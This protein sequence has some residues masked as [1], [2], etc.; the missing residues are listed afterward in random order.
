MTRHHHEFLPRAHSEKFGEMDE[1]NWKDLTVRKNM[2]RVDP[3]IQDLVTLLNDRGYRTFSSCSGGHPKSM[4]GSAHHW[5]AFLAFSPPSR[6]VFKIYFAL[7]KKRRRFDLDAFTGVQNEDDPSEQTVYSELSW[8]LK[9]RYTSKAEYYFEL[10]L[11][12][13]RIVQRLRPRKRSE[14]LLDHVLKEEAGRAQRLLHHH[15]KRLR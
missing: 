3:S 5:Q 6:V 13:S 15:E 1:S 14:N 2:R 8:R 10:F 7:Q 4:R 11:E 12:M 9:D